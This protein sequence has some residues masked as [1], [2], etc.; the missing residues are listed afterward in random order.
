MRRIF[1][2]ILMLSA[3]YASAQSNYWIHTLKNDSSAHV[4]MHFSLD[5]NSSTFTNQF[6]SHFVLKNHIPSEEIDNMYNRLDKINSGGLDANGQIFFLGKAIKN[7]DTTSLR[8]GFSVNSY[9]HFDTRLSK[10][11]IALAFKG[12]S[13]FMSQTANFGDN[14]FQAIS[15]DKAMV[16]LFHK[17]KYKKSIQTIG[18]A[19]GLMLGKN[20]SS[21]FVDNATMYTKFNGEYIDIKAKYNYINVN[22]TSSYY[23]GYGLTMEGFYS[24]E[25]KKQKFSIFLQNMGNI[26]WTRNIKSLR[27][28]TTVHFEGVDIANVFQTGNKTNG[29][30]LAQKLIGTL[31]DTSRIITA[32]IPEF[33][34]SYEQ[35]IG[36]YVGIELC[37]NIRINANYQPLII[38]KLKQYFNDTYYCA[39]DITYGGYGI[40]TYS[41]SKPVAIGFEA[42]INA[43]KTWNIYIKAPNING[44]IAPKKRTGGALYLTLI[45]QIN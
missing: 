35:K 31:R 18:L 13:Q 37:A 6:L 45:K 14:S 29:D 7:N 20:Y 42:L 17:T 5:Y 30:S 41:Q 43:H 10:E 33:W 8:L 28:D 4:G 32:N 11:V 22:N 16:H 1:L 26:N 23:N 38:G 12:N 25:T 40:A 15:Y 34:V 19:M 3:I 21:I 36:P 9:Q 44:L 39:L 24:I 27:K 2:F